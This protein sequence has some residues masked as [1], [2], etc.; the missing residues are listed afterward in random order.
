MAADERIHGEVLRGLAARAGDQLAGT[1]RAA[2]FGAND[3]LVSNLALV[4]GIGAA[5][6]AAS[7][8]LFAG[9]AG[10]LAGALSMG[11]GE[12]V[13][14]GSQREL[15]RHEPDPATWRLSPPPRCGRNELAA[16]LPGSGHGREAEE[17]AR[18]CRHPH[19]DSTHR[20]H[21]GRSIHD[22]R[23]RRLGLAAAISSFCSS[24]P[25]P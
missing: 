1:F 16:R 19:C 22:A 25:A 8:L 14:V 21:D 20:A 11:A 18:P 9:I 23:S 3:G 17:H 24:H 4:L 15:L 7:I 5:G 10:L 12:Y 2:V 6:V 13:S